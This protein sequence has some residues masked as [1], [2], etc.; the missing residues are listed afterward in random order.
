MSENTKPQFSLVGLAEWGYT[1][2]LSTLG[3]VAIYIELHYDIF[4]KL[5]EPGSVARGSAELQALIDGHE[6]DSIDKYLTEADKK[7]MDDELN[8]ALGHCP[9]PTYEGFP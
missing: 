3:E 6:D 9:N 1:M 5:D 2:G 4:W 8:A 7:R